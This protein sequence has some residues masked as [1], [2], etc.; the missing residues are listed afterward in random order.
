MKVSGP[1]LVNISSLVVS[2]GSPPPAP[3]T[4][5]IWTLTEAGVPVRV[6]PS[7]SPPIEPKES[8]WVWAGMRGSTERS[9]PTMVPVASR[10]A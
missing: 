6:T 1:P 3:V 9:E 4:W 5:T 2:I 10:H 7:T 8:N